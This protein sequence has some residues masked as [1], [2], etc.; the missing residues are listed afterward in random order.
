MV[1]QDRQSLII[2]SLHGLG[3]FAEEMDDLIA[4]AEVSTCQFA[5]DERMDNDP[6]LV[7]QRRQGL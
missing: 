1:F 3:E 7:E 6:F 2:S 5:Y 4:W